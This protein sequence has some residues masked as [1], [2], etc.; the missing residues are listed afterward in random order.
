MKN[1]LP[2]FKFPSE[3]GLL[4]HVAE[5]LGGEIRKGVLLIGERLLLKADF[6]GHTEAV[7]PQ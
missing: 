1:D 4:Q 2:V 6:C 5:T 3:V 7:V